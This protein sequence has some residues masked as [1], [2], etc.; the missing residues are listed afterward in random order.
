MSGFTKAH[1]DFDGS[2]LE[3]ANLLTEIGNLVS[4]L[5]LFALNFVVNRVPF[6]CGVAM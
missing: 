1:V 6:P 5:A 4:G 2:L 3:P